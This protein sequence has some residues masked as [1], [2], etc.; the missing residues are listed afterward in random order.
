MGAFLLALVALLASVGAA[1]IGPAPDGRR[2]PLDP[3]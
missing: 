2:R 1:W 3:R